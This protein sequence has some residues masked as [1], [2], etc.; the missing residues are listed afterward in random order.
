MNPRNNQ[1]LPVIIIVIIVVV[2][3]AAIVA[4]A[5]TLLFGGGSSDEKAE[6][7]QANALVQTT[8]DR[9]VRMTIRGPITADEKFR[10]YQITVSPSS[11]VMTT[12][13][14]YLDQQIDTAQ[15]ENNTRAYEEFVYALDRAGMMAGTPLEGDKNDTRGL[16]PGGKILEFETLQNSQTVEKLWTATCGG[17]GG[18][19]KGNASQISNM[20][21]AQVP[22]GQ[23]LLKKINE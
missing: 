16:C 10:S 12:Y 13:A 19:F 2:S 23:D 6:D 15:L 3:V 17:S 11:R 4:L 21:L 7:P 22:Q 5:R 18:S 9:A 1:L 14:G 8:S 20:F